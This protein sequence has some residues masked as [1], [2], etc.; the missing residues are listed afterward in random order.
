MEKNR[1]KGSSLR[2]RSPI[3]AAQ[4]SVRVGS[5]ASRLQPGIAGP[6]DTPLAGS[7][8]MVPLGTPWALR[9]SIH[10]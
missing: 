1:K 2:A 4:R 5:T 7:A 8:F 6:A 10:T 9:S 3:Q